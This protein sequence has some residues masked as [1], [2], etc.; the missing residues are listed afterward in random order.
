MR[1]GLHSKTIH[2][3]KV[4][5]CTKLPWRRVRNQSYHSGEVSTL[6]QINMSVLFCIRWKI[7]KLCE[8]EYKMMVTG[9][10]DLVTKKFTH[11]RQTA[12]CKKLRRQTSTKN[13]LFGKRSFR[14]VVRGSEL[15]SNNQTHKCFSLPLS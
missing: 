6:S 13:S 15:I 14:Q 2:I 3:K 12:K 4:I 8:T 10:K 5:A 1:C 9:E 7:E 11:K